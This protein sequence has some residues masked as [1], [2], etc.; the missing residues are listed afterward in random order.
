MKSVRTKISP[1][2]VTY[3]HK[4]QALFDPDPQIA[5]N[6][7]YSSESPQITLSINNGDKATALDKLLPDEKSF[8]NVTLKIVVD[9]PFTN[10]AFLTAKELFET[11]FDK[12]PVFAY[13]VTPADQ[14]LWFI[15]FCYVV[16]KNCVVQFFNDNLNDCHGVIST[17]Y[18]DIAEEIFEELNLLGVHYCTD[19]ERG[20]LGKP[21]GEWP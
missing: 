14:E 18:Q 21:L 1:P 11:A 9:G 12:N 4:L 10:K 16:F 19:V 8:G 5:F 2:W 17:L 15:D 6:I 20:N 3:I 13:C 7:E